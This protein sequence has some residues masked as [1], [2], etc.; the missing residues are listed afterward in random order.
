MAYSPLQRK[1]VIRRTAEERIEEVKRNLFS[2]DQEPQPT[3]SS[4]RRYRRRRGKRSAQSRKSD[5]PLCNPEVEEGEP[6]PKKRELAPYADADDFSFMED[7]PQ[8]ELQP[9][10]VEVQPAGDLPPPVGP[11][12]PGQSG[13]CLTGPLCP[14]RIATTPPPAAPVECSTPVWRELSLR[15]LSASESVADDVPVVT[16]LPVSEEEMRDRLEQQ[17]LFR[18]MWSP[19]PHPPQQMSPPSAHPWQLL[20]VDIPAQTSG[21]PVT[22]WDPR[23]R[24]RP[25][26]LRRDALRR[27]PTVIPPEWRG[28]GDVGLIAL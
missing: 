15:E 18:P 25:A 21:H 20:P 16:G 26:P 14:V 13:V 8:C 4:R 17:Y 12:T 10:E 28:S 23:G 1:L 27:Q 6:A 7:C 5:D 11:V 9:P 3:R 24:P 19:I 2:D 22:R